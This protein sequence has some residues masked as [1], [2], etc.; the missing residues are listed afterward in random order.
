MTSC[1][2]S[3]KKMP[4][5]RWKYFLI[6][7]PAGSYLSTLYPAGE[8]PA[9]PRL[10]E[11][12]HELVLGPKMSSWIYAQSGLGI[13]DAGYQIIT[14]QM[15]SISPN[16]KQQLNQCGAII[17]GTVHTHKNSLW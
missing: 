14:R 8:Q 15:I 13:H 4:G 3:A 6:V 9:P 1:C 2:F 16:F 12:Q 7:A 17:A 10:L 5:R 11:R